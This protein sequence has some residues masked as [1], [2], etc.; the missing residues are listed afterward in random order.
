MNKTKILLIDALLTLGLVLG[1]SLASPAPQTWVRL[2]LYAAIAVFAVGTAVCLHAN[3]EKIYKS[4]FALY[5]FF[6]V[7]LVAYLIFNATGLLNEVSDIEHLRDLILQSGGW[8]VGLCF[9]LVIVN[10]VILPAPALVFYLAITAVYGS[11][12]AFLI[13]YIST[14][15]GS[16]I[17]FFIGRKL[18]KRAVVWI[19][20]EEDTEKYARLL[21]KKGKL[22]FLIMQLLPFFPDDILCMIAGLS[23][24]SWRFITLS[25]VA[26]KPFYI[27]AACFLGSGELIPFHGWGIPVW[28]VLLA[29]ITVFCIVYFKNQSKIDRWLTN[30]F[31]GKEK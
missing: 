1:V 9:L 5:I 15:V 29:A 31:G 26:V 27:A 23:T 3:K 25:L 28:I 22:P 13:C 30:T 18:G 17:A 10:V 2:L 19:A 12:S 21:D 6:A 24:M 16:L 8:G 20:G 14:V 11:L 4:L 7:V